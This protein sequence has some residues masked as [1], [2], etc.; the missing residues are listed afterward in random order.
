MS[1]P[2]AKHSA[3]TGVSLL[4]IVRALLNS[5]MAAFFVIQGPSMPSLRILWGIVIS[6]NSFAVG[7][8]VRGMAEK[9]ER[10]ALGED[11]K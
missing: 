11:S 9:L 5:A 3:P 4:T 8:S 2:A 6:V 10:R 1:V 7:F